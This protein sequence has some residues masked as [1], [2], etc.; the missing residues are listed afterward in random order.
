[1]R[2]LNAESLTGTWVMSGPGTLYYAAPEQ[3][4]NE[5]Q[6]TDWRTDQFSCG[7]LLSKCA[8][9]LHPYDYGVETL[10]AIAE[11]RATTKEFNEA[12]AKCRYPVLG[13][14]VEGWPV[15]RYRDVSKL[16]Q[17]WDAQGR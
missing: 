11:R 9:G 15:K 13:K 2:D 14:M 1:M 5:K 12:I 4:N 17:E 6:M 8:I 16:I 3:M 7:I 10:Q